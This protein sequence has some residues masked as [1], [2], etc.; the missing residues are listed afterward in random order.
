MTIRMPASSELTAAPAASP[1]TIAC[2]GTK[3]S[4]MERQRHLVAVVDPVAVEVIGRLAV[5]C[6]AGLAGGERQHP[7]G[8]GQ[9]E[10][11]LLLAS[12]RDLPVGVRALDG[13]Q[14]E[15]DELQHRDDPDE[16]ALLA[17][18][19]ELDGGDRVGG[20]RACE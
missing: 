13:A 10:V 4:S 1:W 12:C 2:R 6:L 7:K 11:R 15:R 18:A 19:L 17:M 3:A 16:A 9:R 5:G 20:V 14:R 8:G